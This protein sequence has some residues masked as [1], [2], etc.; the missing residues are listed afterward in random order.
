MIFGVARQS[1]P[2]ARTWHSSFIGI[3]FLRCTGC[4]L[5]YFLSRCSILLVALVFHACIGLF[6]SFLRLWLVHLPPLDSEILRPVLAHAQHGRS[7]S[8]VKH[9]DCGC[10]APRLELLLRFLC[11]QD[12]CFLSFLSCGILNC[13]QRSFL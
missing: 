5:T 9:S 6:H 10:S 3:P 13:F 8:D 11:V 2:A 12:D 1:K 4:F 7:E